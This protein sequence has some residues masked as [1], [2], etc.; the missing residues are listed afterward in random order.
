M[1]ECI[2]HDSIIHVLVIY[3]AIASSL[4]MF[5]AQIISA[6]NWRDYSTESEK[7]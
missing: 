1:R 3:K 4:T 6:E 5:G 7:E 2:C